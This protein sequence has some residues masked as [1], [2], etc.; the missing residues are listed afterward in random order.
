MGMHRH[1]KVIPWL[2]AL[3]VVAASW[4]QGGTKVLA[5]EL[6]NAVREF[7]TARRSACAGETEIV[8]RTVPENIEIP[9]S[10][11]VLH[12]AGDARTQW[13]G[14][15]AVRVEIES[16]GRIV[17]RC[18]VS[19][20]VRTYA[21]VLVAGRPISRHVQPGPSDV[22]TMHMETTLIQRPLLG[23]LASL[24]G[25]RSRQIITQGSI[26]YEDLFESLPLVLQGDRVLV[27]VQSGGVA[28]TTEGIAR[29][30]GGRGD[31]VMVELA[32]RRDRVRARID[33]AQ[34][35]TVLLAEGKGK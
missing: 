9:G 34:R 33:G 20:L 5:G 15:L 19:V 35:V 17:H 13:K 12:V 23:D 4:A 29:E 30:D 2:V 7:I 16:E 28:L 10:A 22:R 27:K 25:M 3:L 32:H 31:Y 18:M 14:A 26:L 1:S 6:E 24:E 11:Y 21:D 8:V